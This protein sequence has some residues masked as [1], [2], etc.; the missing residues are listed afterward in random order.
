M[1]AAQHLPLCFPKKC[2]YAILYFPKLHNRLFINL[3]HHPTKMKASAFSSVHPGNKWSIHALVF[4]YKIDNRNTIV[5]AG[6]RWR[7]S[8]KTVKTALSLCNQEYII[9]GLTSFLV[10]GPF[11]VL[12]PSH[13]TIHHH[14]PRNN[15]ACLRRCPRAPFNQLRARLGASR[16]ARTVR[17]PFV[18]NYRWLS[19]PFSCTLFKHPF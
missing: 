9:N 6:E 18:K 15:N 10:R 7:Q 16:S 1:T 2:I 17:W 11:F 4:S 12:S 14:S 19:S 13:H 3:T 8:H 5:V